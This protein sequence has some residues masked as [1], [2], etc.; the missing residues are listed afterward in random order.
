MIRAA[1]SRIGGESWGKSRHGLR[2]GAW[3]W[4]IDTET[5][6]GEDDAQATESR[7]DN[8]FRWQRNLSITKPGPQT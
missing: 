2:S 4:Q 7:F 3:L 6:S 1:T 5:D 8:L